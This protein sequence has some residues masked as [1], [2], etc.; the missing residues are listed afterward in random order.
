MTAPLD[1]DAARS[2]LAIALEEARRGLDEGGIP[3]GAAL[4]GP[5]GRV[6][7]RGRNRRVQDDDPSLHGET[8]AFRT[9]AGSG[10]TA[11]RRW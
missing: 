5:D 2:W 3:I 6:L 10:P 11:A 1:R 9:P 4:I 8:S 7:G